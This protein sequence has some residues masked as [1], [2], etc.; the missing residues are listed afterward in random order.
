MPFAAARLRS[1]SAI[2]NSPVERSRARIVSDACLAI[3]VDPKSSTLKTGGCA[4]AVAN[5]SANKATAI[6]TRPILHL[7]FLCLFVATTMI[8]FVDFVLHVSGETHS[9]QLVS[10]L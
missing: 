7:R 8:D 5:R 2:V 6:K 1:A 10:V 4:F 3:G 9:M